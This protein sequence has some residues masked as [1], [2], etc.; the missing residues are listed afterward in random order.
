[1][2]DRINSSWNKTIVHSR[3]LSFRFSSAAVPAMAMFGLLIILTTSALGELATVQETNNVAQ[4][5][6][7]EMVYKKGTWAGE[8]NPVV[9]DVHELRQD[10]LLLAR[11]YD[12]SP[13]GYV[14]VPVLK[15]MNPV[16][17]YSDESNLDEDQEG[18]MLQLLRDVLSERM[19]LYRQIYGDLNAVQPS[20]DDVLFDRSQKAGWDRLAVTTK[21]FRVSQSLGVMA[22]AGPLLTSSWHQRAPYNDLCPMGD[23]GRC[24]V[25]CVATSASQI[26]D[27]WEWP[28]SGVG[29]HS[30]F[31]DGDDC[32]GGYVP[33]D[34][35][36][37]DFS[38]SYDWAN[39]PDSCD[40][41]EGCTPAEE[42]ALAELCSEVGISLNM[43]YS[44]CGSGT[45]MAMSIFPTYFKY[46][47]SVSR[48]YRSN[49]TQQSWF[50]VIQDEVNAGRV[51][52]YGIHSHAIVCDGWRDQGGGQ[53]EMHLNYGWG[54]E[55]NAWY[56]LDN[57]YCYWIEGDVCPYEI[58]HV[59]THIE[60]QYD[61]AMVFVGKGTN[62][63]VG[64][65]DDLVEAGETIEITVTVQN[66]GNTAV[67]AT[68]ELSSTDIY[69]DVTTA[70][71]AFDASFGW[72]EQS[73]SL[74]PFVIEVDPACPDPHVAM[75]EL[76]IAAD[77]G[78]LTTKTFYLFIGETPGWSDDIESGE[79]YW[80]HAPVTLSYMDEWHS[81]TYRAHSGSSSWKAGGAGSADHSDLADG[82]LVTPPFLLPFDATLTF[83]HWIDAEDDA[84]MTAWDG[85]IVMISSGD[86]E[87]TQIHPEGGYPYTII[88]N[89]ASPFEPGTPCYSGSSGWTEA[90]FDLSAYSGVVQIMFRFGSDGAVT[91]EGWYI[92]DVWVGN[93][94]SGSDVVVHPDDGA[95]LT[96][97]TVTAAGITTM[98]I[99][100]TGPEPP[101]GFTP[102]PSGTPA[103]YEISTSASFVGPVE[104][105]LEYDEG[106]ISSDESELTLQHYEDV[107]WVDVT[108]SLD[109]EANLVCGVTSS[110]S[111]FLL[112]IGD[113]SCCQ[114]RVG[115]A[116]GAG[117]DEPTIGDVSTMIDALFI[118]GDPV[119]I[120]C[121]AEADV[122]Q[123]GG[124]DP[125][126]TDIT[127]GDIST[128]ID[129]LFIAGPELGL[130]DCL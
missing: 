32:N 14:V 61:P 87:W 108:V 1:M 21:D 47:Q 83:W 34:W 5:W 35:L 113:P 92:D 81:E 96:F 53:L 17:V 104:V 107:Q 120:V 126:P 33:G 65:G 105:C 40:G 27:Y 85:G 23:G 121:L 98:S 8:K 124:A 9:T 12:V 6:V 106:D 3:G 116:N 25:G 51:M 67:N 20:G 76:Q 31:W 72:G 56:I 4:N 7:T 66:L 69:V 71:T 129:Y 49:H 88:D 125:T 26:M 60:P 37:A 58:E 59:T 89:P 70:S 18:G 15:E 91:F 41:A 11:Y 97:S 114:G 119:V 82:G 52:W 48:E 45:S 55:N 95:T 39:I 110:L 19:E 16:K 28:S 68:G 29:S 128:L 24:V 94:P 46:S 90:T 38:D 109:T 44:A 64:D 22:E 36:T 43:G 13:R 62:E 74:T 42:A 54:Q 117:G 127:I 79:G 100:D 118:G 101:G 103:Y 57:L 102:V 115:D 130:P 77:G 112:A 93:T 78:Y 2:F 80:A 122:N 73:L 111:P 123:S 30:Y 99:G 75:F 10:G 86:G 50:E 63:S 84:G